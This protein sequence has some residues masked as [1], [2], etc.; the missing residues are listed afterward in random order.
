MNQH[1]PNDNNKTAYQLQQLLTNISDSDVIRTACALTDCDVVVVG[2]DGRRN[3]FGRRNILIA[4]P[5]ACLKVEKER[6]K[7]LLKEFCL[8]HSTI[9][10]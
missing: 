4:A 2:V 6:G 7:P 9:V 1:K 3:I 5:A 8:F 10:Q